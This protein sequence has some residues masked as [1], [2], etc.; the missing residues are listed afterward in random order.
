MQDAYLCAKR[1]DYGQFC[2]CPSISGQALAQPLVGRVLTSQEIC[3]HDMVLLGT[4]VG[5]INLGELCFGL[6]LEIATFGISVDACTA[7][8]NG[9][10]CSSCTPCISI[11]G[12]IGVSF[13]CPSFAMERCIPLP[14]INST[15][16]RPRSVLAAVPELAR[17]FAL[18]LAG[19][20]DSDVDEDTTGPEE[21]VS[22]EPEEVHEEETEEEAEEEETGD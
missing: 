8:Y 10:E 19:V 7:S 17:D 14:M 4:R 15:S 21:T 13:S 11:G 16:E 6:D 5:D 3:F 9:Y 18:S 1:Q 22:E 20:S 12:R 2:V